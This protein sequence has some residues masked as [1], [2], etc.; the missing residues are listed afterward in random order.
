MK[1][2][3]HELKKY[4]IKKKNIVLS[5]LRR[6]FLGCVEMSHFAS[7]QFFLFIRSVVA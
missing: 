6:S 4:K 3:R 2:F 5:A 7:G 1:T